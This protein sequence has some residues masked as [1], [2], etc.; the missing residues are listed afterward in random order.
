MLAKIYMKNVILFT[1]MSMPGF[2]SSVFAQTTLP[3]LT[4]NTE[5]HTGNILKLSSDAEGKLILT[6]SLDKTAK[7]WDAATGALIRTFH[8]PIDQGNEG[9]LAGCAISPNGKTVVFG[10]S[11]GYTWDK[12]TSV[13]IYDA[14]SGTMKHR[15]KG[16]PDTILDI[17]FS[18]SG[19][20]MVVTLATSNGIRIYN[21][22][23]WNL[24]KSYTD[25]GSECNNA[26]F[27]KSGRMA[28]V[29]YDGRIRLY[30]SS[31]GKEKE[32]RTTGDKKPASISFTP[33][34]SLLA[35]GFRDD[36]K[37]QV[38]D[39]R[40]LKL[41]YEP[42][43]SGT[44][45]NNERL[46]KVSFS[47]DGSKLAAGYS[48]QKKR[49]GKSWFQI[50]VWSNQ[51]R[52]IFTDYPAGRLGIM[53]IKP[54]P[55]NSFIFSGGLPD[56]GLIKSD[57]T[58]GFYKSAETYAFVSVNK[59]N[60]YTIYDKASFKINADGTEI[61]VTPFGA[62]P[63]A[64]SVRNRK[65]IQG[66]FKGGSSPVDSF[67][68]ILVSDWTALRDPKI[69]SRTVS[70][71][72][73]S[74]RALSVDISKDAK[75]I[76]LGCDYNIYCTDGKGKLL[77]TAM[78]QS[79]ANSIN[80]S[81]NNNVVVVG[82][83]DGTLRWY[84]MT[85]GTLLFSLFIHPD[86]RRW[87][88]WTPKGYFDC[89]QGADDLIG[90]HL[91]Q[92]P[93]K[94]AIYY[95]ASQ[96]FEKFYTPNLGSRILSGEEITSSDV[97]MASFK[98][99][100]LVKI[101]SPNSGVRG[102]K[103]VNR[104]IESESGTIEVT[105][106]VTDQGGGVDE[107]LLYNNGKL[108][109]TTNKGFKRDENRGAK[110]IK[111][112]TINLLDGENRILATAFNTQRTEAIADELKIIYK[113]LTVEKSN[114]WLFV[115]GINQY[116]NPKYNLNFAVADALGFRNQVELGG[117]G[118]FNTINAV[119]LTD[120]EATKPRILQEMDMIK[121]Q[122]GPNDVLIFYYAG[123]GVMSEEPVPQFYLIPYDVIQL[124]G[125][126]LGL[127]K[128]GISANELKV[129]STQIKSQK[130]LFIL[131]ACQSGGMTGMLAARGA[132]EEKAVNQLA[133]STGTYWL[134]ASSSEQFAGEFAQLGH[135]IFTYCI[136]E[137]LT[138]KADGQNDKKI[139]VNEL[140][141]YLSDQVPLVSKQYKGSEQ[142]PNAY[143]YG[144][145]FPIMVIK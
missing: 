116:K 65:L 58:T 48:Y 86:N 87:V 98:L 139:T 89:S 55:D 63:M 131:D 129:F 35:V 96:F 41:L 79:A 40:N 109:Q 80:I 9:I 12:T 46:V 93:Y 27:D 91:N 47:Y 134:A 13:Y 117:R 110:T 104:M 11:T 26:V 45:L 67:L 70:F 114:L 120:G 81:D 141:A 136:L 121:S 53:D 17:V 130:Q 4:L 138:G 69:N 30:N 133:R 90:W 82:M 102:F 31:F 88:L 103:P 97:N 8:I 42:D 36:D 111:T 123:H 99:P 3:L 106:D 62:E 112:F 16:F 38:Y 37:I 14:A 107:I 60:T 19:E 101:T 72:Q 1:L 126:E 66:E 115:I 118:I 52:G 108:I 76:V 61:G 119:F 128:N 50:R 142:F 78:G 54:M 10:G 28:T 51:G 73:A 68:G 132:A 84:S 75:K 25:Y 71:M 22:T 85:D 125:N 105:L 15:I 43:I 140:S 95:P 32:V 135:G 77:W 113:K 64:F 122:A 143:G 92:G 56:I 2:L 21:A 18:S 23:N 39:G 145:D 5:M 6:T 100:P 7:L 33:D 20:F 34:G 94:E 74:E 24:I 127:Q 59:N 44:N 144:Q 29:C 137:G 49:D 57:G 83:G 124:Y